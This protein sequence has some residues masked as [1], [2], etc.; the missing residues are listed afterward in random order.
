MNKKFLKNAGRHT[1][2]QGEKK[3]LAKSKSPKTNWDSVL[4]KV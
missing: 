2:E 4:Q 3:N 1:L